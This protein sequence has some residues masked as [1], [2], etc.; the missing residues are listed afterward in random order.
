VLFRST[1]AVTPWGA[2]VTLS[3][4]NVL[5]SQA[6]GNNGANNPAWVWAN[7]ALPT[8][9]GYASGASPVVCPVTR[10][11]YFSTGPSVYA[12]TY[13]GALLW[14]ITSKEVD[15]STRL[16]Y[17]LRGAPAAD[18]AGRLVFYGSDDRRVYAVYAASGLPAWPSPFL[19]TAPVRAPLTV[20]A[21]GRSVYVASDGANLL[22]LDAA[23]GSLLM[24]VSVPG[25]SS[26]G[27]SSPSIAP[28][29]GVLVALAN[30]VLF[31]ANRSLGPPYL[32]WQLQLDGAVSAPVTVDGNMSAYVGTLTGSVYSISA[33]TGA[34]QWLA[35]VGEPVTSPILLAPVTIAGAT[36]PT[37]IAISRRAL[38]AFGNGGVY[39]LSSSGGAPPAGPAAGAIG[40][41]PQTTLIVASVVPSVALLAAVA[42][43]FASGLLKCGPAP[44]ARGAQQKAA[45]L[46]AGGGF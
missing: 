43:A 19:T 28:G 27:R 38:D 13:A 3:D 33:A 11:I 24:S 15:P 9:A 1:P 41:S 14:N 40:L 26:V 31:C 5:R 34:V 46:G 2:I 35:S 17:A 10:N 30:G 12:Y 21:D 6:Y 39:L 23:D 36:V 32:L 4:V 7:R 16:P 37:A 22:E 45:L 29:V 25:G 20:S 18:P 42:G 8:P 44:A